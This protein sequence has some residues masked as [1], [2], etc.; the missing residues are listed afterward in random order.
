MTHVSLSEFFNDGAEDNLDLLEF[1][2]RVRIRPYPRGGGHSVVL[3]DVEGGGRW[4]WGVFQGSKCAAKPNRQLNRQQD[5]TLAEATGE[6]YE[7]ERGEERN[8]GPA[9]S[10]T[11]ELSRGSGEIKNEQLATAPRIS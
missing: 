8:N 9:G 10:M 11:V 3:V 5:S 7:R 1:L 2:Q 6:K 4:R